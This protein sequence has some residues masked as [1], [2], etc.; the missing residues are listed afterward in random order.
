MGDLNGDGKLE[1]IIGGTGEMA[2]YQYPT[3]K[4]PVTTSPHVA[5]ATSLAVGDINGNGGQD[6][7]VTDGQDPK[8]SV[9]AA[10]STPEPTTLVLL[11]LGGAVLFMRR[12]RR[13][14][15]RS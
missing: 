10:V 4:R 3:W 13:N 2:F 1:V 12:R 8:G 6:I 11:V 14:R 9:G 7:I 15:S 5:F